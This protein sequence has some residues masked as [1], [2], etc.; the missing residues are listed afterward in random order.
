MKAFLSL[1]LIL[2]AAKLT[3]AQSVITGSVKDTKG[4]PMPGVFVED[5]LHAN[6]VLTDSLGNFRI[7]ADTHSPLLFRAYTFKD[8]TVTAENRHSGM[9]VVMQASLLTVARTD[10]PFYIPANPDDDAP[11]Q[12]PVTDKKQR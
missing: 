1:F 6:A 7:T 10:G 3:S 5:R 9:K 4:R 2:I 8:R 12:S 11:Q